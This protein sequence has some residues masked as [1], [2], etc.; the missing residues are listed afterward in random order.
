MTKGFITIATGDKHYY[1]IAANL[2]LSYRLFSDNPYPF[3]IIAEEENEYTELFDDVIISNDVKRSFLDKFLLLKLCPYDETIF[4]DADC[5]AYGDLNKY[6][7][8]FSGATDFSAVGQNF[9][10]S[11]NN[12][13]WYNLDGIGKYGE[14]INYKTRV[15]AGVMYVRKTDRIE[16]LYSDCMEMCENFEAFHF[17]TCPFSIDECVLGVALPLNNMKATEE[18]PPMIA[19]YPMLA[20]LKANVYKKKLCYSTPWHSK[21][22]GILLH[23]GTIQTRQAL[24]KY[25]IEGLNCLL[26]N[27]LSFWNDIKYKYGFRLFVLR[28][29]EIP[30]KAKTIICRI[31][32]KIKKG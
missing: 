11:D 15:H 12:G 29:K 10:L 4:F 30:L 20:K 24:Y 26:D 1:K 23:W 31:K 19:F 6:W 17:H 14:L 27:K 28:I 16:K 22:D 5:L 7:D 18:P 25:N 21:T 2:L 13:A 9:D 3:A 8:F 32:K